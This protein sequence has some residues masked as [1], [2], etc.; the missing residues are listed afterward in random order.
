[1]V[2]LCLVFFIFS[3]FCSWIEKNAGHTRSVGHPAGKGRC[4]VFELL[5]SHL[6][7]FFI[8]VSGRIGAL[9]AREAIHP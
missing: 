8:S 3:G 9:A 1:M 4:R 2:T 5:S 6:A 7:L